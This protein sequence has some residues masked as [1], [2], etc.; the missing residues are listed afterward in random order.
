[1]CV[2]QVEYHKEYEAT[3]GQMA[4]GEGRNREI[5]STIDLN[6]ILPVNLDI[7]YGSPM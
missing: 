7:D 2:I 5:A 6:L 1:M 4:A 3:R